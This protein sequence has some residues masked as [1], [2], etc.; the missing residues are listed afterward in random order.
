[1][2]VLLCWLLLGL[3]FGPGAA[4]NVKVFLNNKPFA[5]KVA[6]SP[7]DLYL[8]MQ[9]VLKAL[10]K[11]EVLDPAATSLE[12]EG[13][14]LAL[15][16]QGG[17][18]MCRAK[19]LCQV[20]GGRYEF[21]TSVGT[22]DIYAYD[23]TA[24]AREALKR[25]LSLSKVSSESDFNTLSLL[26]RQHLIQSMGLKLDDGAEMKMV[27]QQEMATASGRGDLGCYVVYRKERKG[28]G[29]ACYLFHV[30]SLQSPADTLHGMGWAWGV[31]WHNLNGNSEDRISSRA[32]GDW[33]AYALVR[34]VAKLDTYRSILRG[35]ESQTEKDL[36]TQFRDTER[37]GGIESVL[38]LIKN[39]AR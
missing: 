32:F 9:A 17:V 34:D 39:Q 37:T 20:F 16:A 15:Q 11:A 6:G 14:A 8:E 35:C 31:Q 38:S 19:D 27:N 12:L 23:P 33:V 2:R 26:T 36:F 30:R 22:V 28:S 18:A 21:N 1:M 25:V 13:Q 29:T 24:A 10:G 7:G 3:L 5:G 4:Q